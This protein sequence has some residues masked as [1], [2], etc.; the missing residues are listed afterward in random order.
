MLKKPINSDNAL[1][2]T[3][4][5]F[6]NSTNLTLVGSTIS[7]EIPVSLGN[8]TNLTDLMLSHNE[9]TGEIPASLGNLTAL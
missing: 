9:L 1:T 6:P 4:N 2:K 7:G 8:C 5:H 3:S